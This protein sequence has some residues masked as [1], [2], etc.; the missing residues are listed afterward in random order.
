MSATK[1]RTILEAH[2][3]GHGAA[4]LR[5]NLGDGYLYRSNAVFRT[6]RTFVRR[7]GYRFR[8]DDSRYAGS[9]LFSLDRLLCERTVPYNDNVSALVDLERKRPDYFRVR[10]VSAIG[11]RPNAVFHEA[12]HAMCHEVMHLGDPR[13]LRKHDE[14]ALLLIVL[15]ESMVMAGEHLAWAHAPTDAVGRYM[16]SAN[17]YVPVRPRGDP[18]VRGFVRRH[19][20]RRTYSLLA[21]AILFTWSYRSCLTEAEITYVCELTELDATDASSR[22]DVE[23]AYKHFFLPRGNVSRTLLMD[24]YLQSRGFA[25]E[26][27]PRGYLPFAK[28][29]RAHGAVRARFRQF[30]ELISAGLPG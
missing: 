28:A 9:A 8:T 18:L 6:V 21:L 1:L 30:G 25:R 15:I 17:F 7:A 11:P 14:E 29:L 22:A 16:F 20:P 10:D 3:Q 19:G 2:Q 26:L 27:G 24:F 13:A 4:T 5:Q 23:S 12:C